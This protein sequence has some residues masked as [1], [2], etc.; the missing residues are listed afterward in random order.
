[1]VS[2]Q[3]IGTNGVGLQQP[4]FFPPF[5]TASLAPQGN[6]NNANPI[7]GLPVPNVNYAL[8]AQALANMFPQGTALGALGHGMN[9]QVAYQGSPRQNLARIPT[10]AFENDKA[11]PFVL[12]P[13]Y[14]KRIDLTKPLKDQRPVL[15]RSR[16][17]REFDPHRDRSDY[18]EVDDAK[19]RRRMRSTDNARLYRDREKQ[20]MIDLEDSI[21]HLKTV[22]SRLT[23]H[24]TTLKYKL[25][26]LTNYIKKNKPA[27]VMQPPEHIPP[28]IYAPPLN[29]GPTNLEQ[30]TQVRD[31]SEYSTNSA[32]SGAGA[33]T[34]DNF[35]SVFD[36]VFNQHGEQMAQIN[37]IPEVASERGSTEASSSGV[38]SNTLS[39]SGKSSQ[40]NRNVRNLSLNIEN[41]NHSSQDNSQASSTKTV[42]EAV[43]RASALQNNAN[44][45]ISIASSTTEWSRIQD[46]PQFESSRIEGGGKAGGAPLPTPDTPSCYG[47]AEP[48]PAEL[49]KASQQGMI[50]TL[51]R[52][53]QSI[54]DI[55]GDNSAPNVGPRSEFVMPRF[56]F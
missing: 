50:N 38:E 43:A 51:P 55:L 41:S 11:E 30:S 16:L 20:R 24:N 8:Q 2:Q 14:D 52:S 6:S 25:D 37:A 29:A 21:E 15:R 26:V 35:G 23:I 3:Q 48:S 19:V 44:N 1:M 28:P 40:R 13:L 9:G 17:R 5:P 49:A 7:G 54:N 34:N 46:L 27:P 32:L 53:I 4:I 12:A 31:I 39:S 45:N 36:V 33:A 10:P 18:N 56:T 22:N 47:S 42:L